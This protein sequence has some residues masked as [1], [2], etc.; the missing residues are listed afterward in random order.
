MSGTTSKP[1]KAVSLARV[2]ALISGAEKHLPNGSFN[3]GATAFTTASLVQLLQSLADATIAVN[4]AHT[5]LKDAL[6]A[7]QTTQAKVGP[8]QR[9]F[10][11]TVQGMFAGATQ[12]LADFGLEPPKARKPRTAEQL[13]AAKA[14]AKATR[15]S[16]GTTSKKQKLAIHGNVTG[17]DIVPITEPAAPAKPAPQEASNASGQPNQGTSK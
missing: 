9:A 12:T 7:L 15:A 3:V 16:R 4:T 2:Q 10:R 17:V 13:A 11:R 6:A 5:A 1:S 14:K 8:T